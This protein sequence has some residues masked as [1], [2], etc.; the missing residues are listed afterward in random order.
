MLGVWE[1]NAQAAGRSRFDWIYADGSGGAACW[2][3]A[4]DRGE[5]VGSAGLTPR[6]ITIKGREAA[7]AQAIDLMIDH[8]HRVGGAALALQRAL[9]AYARQRGF[10]LVYTFPS[11]ESEAIQLRGGYRVLG[12]L[13]RWT[14]P[15]R[16]EEWL[17]ERI[18]LPAARILARVID[19]AMR[20]VSGRR[21]RRHGGVVVELTKE[22][23]RRFDDLWLAASRRFDVIAERSAAYLTW[24]FVRCPHEQYRT[25]T[26]SDAE[27][28]LIGYVVYA[29]MDRS[30]RIVDLLVAD[31]GVLDTLVPEF[32]LKMRRDG[33]SAV[34][35]T[36]FG[37]DAVGGALRRFGFYRRPGIHQ[38]LVYLNDALP[39]D[40]IPLDKASWYLTEGDR[41]V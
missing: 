16:S 38:V 28:R 2:L 4:T 40:E 6:A 32:M 7:A 39:R 3:A 26:L 33:I 15:L 25:L 18:G 10:A 37:C 9:M 34:T 30:V 27:G 13:E 29:H 1:R 24:R 23:D 8:G 36:Y 5:V 17:R 22:F 19:P 35:F 20:A 12:A 21:Y 11:R 31:F 14:R 41:D